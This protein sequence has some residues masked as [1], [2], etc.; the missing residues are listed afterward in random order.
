M[1]FVSFDDDRT[2]LLA[3]DDCGRFMIQP[4]RV[5]ESAWADTDPAELAAQF[6]AREDVIR[7]GLRAGWN[8]WAQRREAPTWARWRCPECLAAAPRLRVAAK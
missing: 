1:G 3:C 2:G 8:W 4:N 5:S 6:L 7:A